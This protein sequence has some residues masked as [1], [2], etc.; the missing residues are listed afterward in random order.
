MGQQKWANFQMP[1]E[2]FPGYIRRLDFDASDTELTTAEEHDAAQTGV[3]VA[4][5]HI[6]VLMRTSY[7]PAILESI[8]QSVSALFLSPTTR[9]MASTPSALDGTLSH[10]TSEEKNYAE[11][12][13]RI[14][15]NN[16]IAHKMK[17]FA[18][19]LA[20]GTITILAVV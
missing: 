16:I 7:Q 11:S 2:L 13:H 3:S 12:E 6:S 15:Q 5:S 18:K 8:H 19:R 10:T 14:N 9:R 17:H 20:Q 4:E 1:N